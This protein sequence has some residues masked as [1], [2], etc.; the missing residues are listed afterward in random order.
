M[1]PRRG[2]ERGECEFTTG[3]GLKILQNS[4]DATE[5]E[6]AVVPVE[7]HEKLDSPHVVRLVIG[8]GFSSSQIILEII[9]INYFNKHR[10]SSI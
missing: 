4:R 6:A 3:T 1:S 7:L 8:L 9:S 5:L 10:S 2:R